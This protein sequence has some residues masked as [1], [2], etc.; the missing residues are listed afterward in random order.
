MAR[1]QIGGSLIENFSVGRSDINV[2]TSGEALITKLIVSSPLTISSTGANSGTGDVTIGFSSANFVT[3]FNTRTGAITL[4]GT[5]VTNALGYTPVSGDQYLGTV[6]SITAGTGL[7]GGTITASGTISL[8][9]TAVTAGSYTNSNITVD[10]Q[11]RIT[12]ASNGSGGGGGGSTTVV[13]NGMSNNTILYQSASSFFL[14]FLKIEYYAVNNVTQDKQEAGIYIATFN[15]QGTP[16]STIGQAGVMTLG[17]GMILQFTSTLI[18]GTIPTV[19]VSNNNM[20]A[21][22]V[23]F[24]VTEI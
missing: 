3:S 7:S 24:K 12:A 5:D 11:G 8:A 13:V 2:S 1:T 10:A 9:N 14:G 17:S 23:V 22:S 4:T 19:Y 15:D 16:T 21:Y 20:D 6:T 18:S